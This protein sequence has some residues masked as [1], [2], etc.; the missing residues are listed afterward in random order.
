MNETYTR[1]CMIKVWV[2]GLDTVDR[3]VE[4]SYDYSYSVPLIIILRPLIILSVSAL[5]QFSIFY[6][7]KGIRLFVGV[8][9]LQPVK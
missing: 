8:V 4:G 9:G 3:V 5:I 7:E 1:L 6:K 2:S